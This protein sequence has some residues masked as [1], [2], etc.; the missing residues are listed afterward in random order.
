MHQQ[1]PNNPSRTFS[2]V[3]TFSS[4]DGFGE[5]EY[6]KQKKNFENSR[7]FNSKYIIDINPKQYENEKNENLK[8]F[9][10]CQ[11]EFNK[12]NWSLNSNETFINNVL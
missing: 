10:E 1:R 7:E 6:M 3:S 9:I 8:E 5:K 2:R 12:N 4:F 11:N